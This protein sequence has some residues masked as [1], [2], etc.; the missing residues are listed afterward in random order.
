MWLFL[1]ST[2][3][4]DGASML[5]GEKV[6]KRFLLEVSINQVGSVE[7][8]KLFELIQAKSKVET[9]WL[10]TKQLSSIFAIV[11]RVCVGE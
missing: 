7:Y 8:N 3:R 6:E 9:T 4:L 10:K 5:D 1:V 2:N 11:R